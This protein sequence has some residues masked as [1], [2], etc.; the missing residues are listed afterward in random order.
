MKTFGFGEDIMT[1]EVLALQEEQQKSRA[2]AAP[3]Q[4]G[5]CPGCS[6]GTQ[7]SFQRTRRLSEPRVRPTV[8]GM[9]AMSVLW[10]A[11]SLADLVA[12]LRRASCS[13]SACGLLTAKAQH[14]VGGRGVAGS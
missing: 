3:T 6:S 8:T 4:T 1:Q 12:E 9:W 7:T 2:S 11:E 13:G 10:A 5:D 14:R